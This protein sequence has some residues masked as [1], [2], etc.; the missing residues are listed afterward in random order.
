MGTHQ[1]AHQPRLLINIGG[2]QANLGDDDEIL[3]LSR[4][5]VPA[6]EAS[7]AGNGVI[8][9]ALQHGIPV[10]HMLNIRSIAAMTGIPYDT[11]PKPV[12][13]VRANPWWSAAGLV[14]F[15]VVLFTHRRW[16]LE[17]PDSTGL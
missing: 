4:G 2:A 14:L 15:S 9:Y 7:R 17:A 11:E 6:S 10:I 5:P 16:K 3:R 8:A 13:P 1:L 12:A